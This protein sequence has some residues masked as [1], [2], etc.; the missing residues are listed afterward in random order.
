M[1]SFTTTVWAGTPGDRWHLTTSKDQGQDVEALRRWLST[2]LKEKSCKFPILIITRQVPDA[3]EASQL[4]LFTEK[5][6]DGN[7]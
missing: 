5:K 4:T 2:Q 3:Q 7:H 6:N 1:K